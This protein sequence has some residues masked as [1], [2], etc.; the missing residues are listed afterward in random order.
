MSEQMVTLAGHGL[1][2]GG[3]G[4]VPTTAQPNPQPAPTRGGDGGGGPQSSRK[5]PTSKPTLTAADATAGRQLPRPLQDCP[6]RRGRQT[7][8]R[9][10][11]RPIHREGHAQQTGP[12]LS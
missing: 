8:R 2:D 1:A 7:E 11:A 4:C 10:G 12:D 9:M 6:G 3:G 5:R